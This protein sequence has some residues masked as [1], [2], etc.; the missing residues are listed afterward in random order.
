MM[1]AFS[2]LSLPRRVTGM[3]MLFFVTVMASTEGISANV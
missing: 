1:I 3:T 2:K